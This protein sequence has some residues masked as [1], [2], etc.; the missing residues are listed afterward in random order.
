MHLRLRATVTLRYSQLGF[1]YAV[2]RLDHI[3]LL[4]QPFYIALCLRYSTTQI[5][6]TGG[7]GICMLG[8]STLLRFEIGNF[9]RNFSRQRLVIALQ[10]LDRILLI[11]GDLRGNLGDF[12]RSQLLLGHDVRQGLARL[13]QLGVRVADFLIKNAQCLAIYHCLTGFVRC[14]AHGGQQFAPYV[15]QHISSTILR[16]Q[17]SESSRRLRSP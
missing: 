5:G 1:L 11:L 12:L 10:R 8:F 7:I 14:T 16:H 9:F 3:N 15:H 4:F 13:V 2:S 6:H 17:Q